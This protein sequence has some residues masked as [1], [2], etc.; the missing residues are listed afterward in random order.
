MAGTTACRLGDEFQLIAGL[1][2]GIDSIKV[3][4]TCRREQSRDVNGRPA[5]E[6]TADRYIGQQSA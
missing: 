5:R 6:P 1:A 3:E 4:S 2:G